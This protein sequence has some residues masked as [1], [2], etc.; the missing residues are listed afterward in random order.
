MMAVVRNSVVAASK[1]RCFSSVLTWLERHSRPQTGLLRVV[2]WHRIDDADARPEHYPGMISASPELFRE[3][4]LLLGS[5]YRV[6]SLA[7]VLAASRGEATLPERAVLLTFDDASCDFA[8][9]AWP[10][11]Q[12]LGL[13][14]TVFVPTAYPDQPQLH[15]WW[16]R[17]Y[18]ALCRSDAGVEV[19]LPWGATLLLEKEQRLAQFRRL[20]EHLKVI[21]HDSASELTELICRQAAVPDPA[22]NGVLSWNA[23]RRLHAEGV[24][25]APHTQTHPMLSQLSADE[26][27]RE[28]TGSRD[29]LAREMGTEVPPVVAYP[30][31]GV[32]AQVTAAMAEAGFELGMTT[33]RGINRLPSSS[34]YL[35]KRINIGRRTTP[36]VLRAQLL[37]QFRF[38]SFS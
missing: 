31:G 17:L 13:P 26:I 30:A 22:E 8:E 10:V 27:L 2:T 7:D 34:P 4:C 32:D 20:K 23:L 29:D 16:D 19:S 38:A 33:R 35:L 15:F 3:Q 25:L 21:P 37:S 36:G 14:V 28:L 18:R 24:T 5:L 11:L 9:H 1:T 12:Q 6:V